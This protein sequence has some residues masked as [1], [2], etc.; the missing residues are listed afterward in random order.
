MADLR[1]RVAWICGERP[2]LRVVMTIR[3]A[4][5]LGVA[6]VVLAGLIPGTP[7]AQ[8]IGPAGVATARDAAAQSWQQLR[9]GLQA[10]GITPGAD[11]VMRDSEISAA[12]SEPIKL[13]RPRPW[14]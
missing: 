4:L 1:Q 7:M 11:W 8:T 3:G 12:A 9:D 13:W 5:L 14:T 2:V 10:W 6:V